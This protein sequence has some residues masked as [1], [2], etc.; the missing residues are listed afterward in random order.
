MK[1]KKPVVTRNRY[2]L[3]FR[4]G[5]GKMYE[6]E[7]TASNM[8]AAVNAWGIVGGPVPRNCPGCRLCGLPESYQYCEKA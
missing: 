7:V 1:S 4:D 3:T 8:N 6:C 5:G 2:R